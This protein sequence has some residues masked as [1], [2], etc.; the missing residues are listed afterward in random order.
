M[1]DHYIV[2]QEA[3]TVLRQKKTFASEFSVERHRSF[4]N[5]A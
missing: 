3:K 1:D 2:S 5:D 4:I